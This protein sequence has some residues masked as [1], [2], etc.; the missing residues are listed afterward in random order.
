[1]LLKQVDDRG[2][3]FFTNMVSRK[4]RELLRNP[5]ASFAIHWKALGKQ[6][7]VEGRAVRVSEEEAEAYWSTRPRPSQ[8][9]AVASRQSA[10][11]QRRDLLMARWLTLEKRYHDSSVPRPKQWTGIRIVPDAIEFWEQEEHRLHRRELFT[12]SRKRW[13]RK[14]LQP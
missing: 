7:R 5:Y 14:L 3:I 10:P 2:F 1:V 13:R 12:R 11:L 9:A 6:V 4:G 8:L